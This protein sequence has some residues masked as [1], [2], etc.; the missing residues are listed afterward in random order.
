MIRPATHS[1]LAPMFELYKEMVKETPFC[2][3][4][5]KVFEHTW[6]TMFPEDMR[7]IYISED[8]K[9]TIDG[10]V[11]GFL[12]YHINQGTP[13]AME[14]LWYVVPEKRETGIGRE[15][16]NNFESWAKSKGAKYTVIAKPFRKIKLNGK[17]R[18]YNS[19]ETMFV[20]EI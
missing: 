8:E 12:F 15:L 2:E 9:H 16:L 7:T 4:N 5:W 18:G 14:S 20:K 1:D 19:I 6:K 3:P 11:A 10:F 17:M 13:M